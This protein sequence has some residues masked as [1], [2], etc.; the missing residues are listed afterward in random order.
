MAITALDRP[1]GAI[2]ALGDGIGFVA[3]VDRMEQDPALK[4]VNSARIS[5]DK[6][7]EGFEDKDRKLCSFL[8]EHGHTSPFRHSFF[9]FHWKA[10]LFVFRQAFKYQVGSGW[11][12]Y[13]VDGAEVSLE[14]FDVMFDTDKGCSWNEVSGRYVRWTPEFYVPTVMRANPPHGNKQASFDLPEDFDHAGERK[15]MLAECEDAFK[16][17]EARI[18]RGVAKE[19]ARMILPQSLYTQAYWTVSLQGVLHF[20]QQR[21]KPDAQYEIRVFAE[22]VRDLVKDDLARVGVTF[23]DA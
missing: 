22:A 2:D 19:I 16:R 11:R 10:P 4:V 6:Q 15:L 21:L 12:T 3:L 8:W 23:E 9:T 7:K 20:L 14:V 5:Y 13:E 17:Y 18:E 1:E